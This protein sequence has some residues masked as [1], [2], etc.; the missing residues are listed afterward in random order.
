[1]HAVDLVADDGVHVKVAQFREP[2]GVRDDSPTGEVVLPAGQVGQGGGRL[3]DDDEVGRVN[4][5]PSAWCAV[6][7]V[8]CRHNRSQRQRGREVS[9]GRDGIFRQA[10]GHN[11]SLTVLEDNT[12][13]HVRQLGGQTIAQI[14]VGGEGLAV[15]RE[16]LLQLQNDDVF[17]EVG[18]KGE[19]GSGRTRDHVDERIAHGIPFAY[20]LR[21]VAADEDLPVA[22]DHFV[23]AKDV[24]VPLG[25]DVIPGG[26]FLS[27]LWR[28]F[29][30][31]RRWRRAPFARRQRR[32]EL[33]FHA[34]A[35][36]RHLRLDADQ[37]GDAIG[38]VNLDVI[39]I[40][41]FGQPLWWLDNQVKADLFAHF[42]GVNQGGADRN[43][44]QVLRR[45]DGDV[46]HRG[47]DAVEVALFGIPRVHQFQGDVRLLT[48]LHQPR[49]GINAIPRFGDE[50]LV[51]RF[52]VDQHQPFISRAGLHIRADGE[53]E[54]SMGVGGQFANAD[55]AAAR[56]AIGA[57]DAGGNV[58]LRL[59]GEDGVGEGDGV[60]VVDGDLLRYHAVVVAAKVDA[61]GR[62]G[63][64]RHLV[65]D[66]GKCEDGGVDVFN[67]C[68]GDGPLGDN[69]GF[70]YDDEFFL[71][72][73]AGDDGDVFVAEENIAASHF[74]VVRAGGEVGKAT[75]AGAVLV[76]ALH[77]GLLDGVGDGTCGDDFAGKVR[78][79]Q[80][81]LSQ[82]R[83]R[84]C[85]H[86]RAQRARQLVAD[87]YRHGNALRLSAGRIYR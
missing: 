53:E 61:V 80:R 6:Q 51:F 30:W 86:A 13:F 56:G 12:H 25:N 82:R 44:V 69:G 37:G 78:Q 42:Q 70:V 48:G 2:G 34:Q 35:A 59:P 58:A 1:M 75:V 8:F 81:R 22:H 31:R 54:G 14:E 23:G 29:S 5:L 27:V 77:V 10:H 50:V 4:L 64:P 36:G 67:L 47:G 39:V 26:R 9:R 40:E 16:A 11:L 79:P 63:Q 62:E 71:D 21:A 24:R 74:Q 66:K 38:G 76:A 15:Q 28:W 49:C 52:D 32:N 68:G 84:V 60:E 85:F 73:V 55:G 20:R 3:R 46:F 19:A 45:H 33:R 87:I 65:G 43:P 17:L 7:E 72:A 41:A 83:A 18:R 57:A